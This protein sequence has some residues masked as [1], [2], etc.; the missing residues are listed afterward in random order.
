MRYKD[1]VDVYAKLESTTKRLA[2]TWAISRLLKE[3]NTDDLGIIV[4]LLQGK[5]F[6]N[7]DEHK[8][9]IAARLVIKAVNISTGIESDKIENEWAKIGDIG[10]V[11]EN[12]ISKKRQAT[13]FQRELSVSKVFKNIQKL[14]EMEGKGSVDQKMKL[15]AELLTSA[16]PPEAKYIVRTLLEDLRVGVADGTLRDAIT[17]AFFEKEIELKY[18]EENNKIDIKDRETY[19]EYVGKIQEAYDITNDFSKVALAV[20]KDG[21]EGLKKVLL[22][23]GVPLKVMLAPKVNTIKEGLERTGKPAEVEYKYDGF[24]VQ[25]HKDSQHVKIFTRRLENVTKQF[26]ELVKYVNSHVKGESCILDCEAV[27]FDPKTQKHL[28]FQNIS[29]R[30]R[31]KYDIEDMAK[32]FPV[33][34]NVFDVIYHDGKNMIKEPFSERRKLIE[35]IIDNEKRKIRVS[36]NMIS[37]DDEEIQ[38]FYDEAL[39]QGYEGIM[40]KR[41]DSI[42]KPGARVGSWVK[43]KPTME[44]LDLVIVGAEWGTG[45]RGKWLSSFVIACVDD[46]GEFLEI[47]KVG[48]GVKEKPEEGLSFDELTKLLEPLIVNKKG[49]TVQVRPKIVLEINYEE[50]QKSPN[51]SSGYA[52]RFP[53]VVRLRDDRKPEDCS[54][55]EMVEEFYKDQKK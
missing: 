48:T 43:I 37:S 30:I 13:L 51:Y 41:M 29:Q 42:Y 3:C 35:K 22:N 2:K 50:I 10:E 19:N 15:I 17:W 25:V 4:L 27:G 21:E 36:K 53:R 20:Q 55:I 49:R 16:S 45:K 47:G 8:I 44:T 40:M 24:R 39:S 34:L 9:G 23:V 12:F 28:P 33:E 14:A 32:K 11:T 6:P 52:L 7:W 5:A 1:L 46:N 18:L 26:P 31:R 54:D 38:K